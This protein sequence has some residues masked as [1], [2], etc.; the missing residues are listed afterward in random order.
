MKRLTIEY[1]DVYMPREMCSIGR[2]GY[3]DDCDT[4]MEYC[5]ADEPGEGSHCP[6]CA[7][8]SALTGLERMKMHWKRSRRSKMNSALARNIRTI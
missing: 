3:V 5:K 6:E 7:V 1:D 8:L 2:D 4:C